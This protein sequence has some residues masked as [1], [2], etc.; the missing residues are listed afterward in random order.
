MPSTPGFML[1]SEAAKCL[2]VTVGTVRNWIEA[3]TLRAKRHPVN[4]YRMILKDDIDALTRKIQAL[5]TMAKSRIRPAKSRR[6]SG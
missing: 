2:G 4:G 6:K 3:G 5:P 1:V